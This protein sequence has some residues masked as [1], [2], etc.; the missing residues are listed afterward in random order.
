MRVALAG[1]V[2]VVLAA[3]G[4]SFGIATAQDGERS[5]FVRFVENQLSTPDRQI[6]LGEID[7]ALSSDVRLSQITIADREGVWLTVENVHL[8]WSRLA[9]LRGRLDVDLLE[10]DSIT[11]ER[12]PIAG[13][14]NEPIDDTPFTLPDL[15]VTI[16]LDRLS[17][18]EVSIAEGIIGPAA[19]LGIDGEIALDDGA[20]DTSLQIERR[21]RPGTLGL[22]ASFDSDSRDLAVDF[23]VSEPEDGVIAN[24]L[25]VE[26]RPPIEFAIQGEGPLGEF[27]AQIALRASGETL[28]Q[29]TTRIDRQE[30]GLA[31]SA[32]LAGNIAALV[33][34]L[35][36]PFVDA[37]TNLD[38]DV[39]RRDDGSV[40]VSRGVVESGVASVSFA[41]ELGADYVPT[42][43]TFQAELENPDG[44]PI[45][46][47][48]GG[49][50]STVRALK[51]DA[52]LGG[53][54]GERFVAEASL[55]DLDT[56]VVATPAATVR[57]EGD[58]TNLSDPAT[59]SVTFQATGRADRL[60]SRSDAVAD[61]L[62]SSLALDVSGAW[63]AGA[64][65][66]ITNASL[67]TDNVEAAFAGTVGD[68]LD[69]TYR[70]EA[71]NIEAFEGLAGRDLGGTAQLAAE[72]SV[73]FSGLINLG[74]DLT[75]RNLSVGI[76]PV[77]GLL[78]GATEI[79]GRVV[80]SETGIAFDAL[81]VSNPQLSVAADGAVSDTEANLEA[82]VEL[83]DLAALN[84]ET[85]GP[86]TARLTVT[87]APSAPEVDAQVTSPGLTLQDKTLADLQ[88]GFEG[89]LQ[90]ESEVAFDLDGALSV[91]ASYDGAPVALTAQI[92]T[93]EAGR[94][95]RDLSADIAGATANGTLTLTDAGRA[96]GDLSLDV[97]DLST[98]AS[99]ALTE[100]SGS[101]QADVSL[102]VRDED[103]IASVDLTARGV[104]VADAFSLEFAS[105]D[106][107][108]E[109]VFGVPVIE[110][111]A[112][113]LGVEAA[114]FD[115]RSVTLVSQREGEA[116]VLSLNADVQGA[117][118]EATGR[119]AK[120]EDGFLAALSAFEL[121]R[122]GLDARLVAPAEVRVVGET[123]TISDV[124]LEVGEGRLNLE[125]TA[126]ETLDLSASLDALPLSIA[127][128]VR[129][130]L[131]VGGTVSG[132]LTLTGT[133]EAPVADATLRAQ[134]V[135]AALLRERGIEPLSIDADASY[136]D[137][138]ATIERLATTVG[139]G[140]L[141]AEGTVGEVLDLTLDVA[142]LPLA[143][144]NAAQPELDVSGTLSGEVD[145]AGTLEAPRA[146]F[147]ASLDQATA[148]PL[149]EAGIDPVDANVA[150]SFADGTATIETLSANVGG[151]EVS[152]SGTVGE[153]LDLTASVRD[154][155]LSLA[156]AVRPDLG[157]QGALSAEVT[158]TGSLEAPDVRFEV[159]APEVTAAATRSAG[160]PAAS[161][162]ASGTANRTS[163]T[164]SEALITIG[165]G[166]AS[167]EG[168]AGLDALDLTVTLEALPLAL[169]NVASPEL[170]VRGSLSGSLDVEGT[171]ANPTVRFD[172]DVPEVSAEPTR[173][174][175]LP[176]ASA[177][178]AGVFEDGTARLDEAVVEVGGGTARA[179]GTVGR[180]LALD[181]EVTGLPLGLANA[182]RPELGLA[183]T[184]SANASA[185]GLI[186]DPNVSFDA[187]VAGFS[188]AQLESA[189]VGPLQIDAA[190]SFADGT[191]VIQSA[192]A[193]GSQIALTASGTV[194]LSG[195]GL[196]VTANARAPLSLADRFVASRG[197]R[198]GGEVVA[199]VRVA[200]SLANP[201]VTGTIEGRGVTF[202]DPQT[203]VEI[204]GGTLVVRL[205]GDSAV[206]ETFR[207]G[208]GE[209][210]ITV[211]G[212]VGIGNGFPA[213]I[214]I[215]LD[216]A[217]YADGRLVTVTLDG[218]LRITGP[219]TEGPLIAGEVLIDR[220]EITVP[221]S[222]GGGATLIEV[223]HMNLPSDVAET[224]RRAE[225]GPFAKSDEGGA[226]GE[227]GGLRLDVL[228]RAPARVFVRGRGIDAELGGEVRITGPIG[229]IS[230]I[231]QLE[232]IR[233]RLVILGQRIVFTE[234]SLAFFGD[235]NPSIRLVAETAT[236]E[237]T[238]RV[239]I[240]GPANEPDIRFESVPQLPQDEVLAQ[241]LFGRSI[242]DLSAFQ[243]AQ[244]AAAVA[245]LAGG[246][247]GPSILDQV[248]VATGLDNL[249][250]ITD[251]QGNTAAQAGRYI[252]DN[253]YVGVRAGESSGVT[254]NLDV[255]R[256]LTVRGEALTDDTSLGVY[257]ELEY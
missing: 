42:E 109:D 237:V 128:V 192:S 176:P 64:P 56:P 55:T 168:T 152:A 219:L 92:E 160:L 54:V 66:R 146:E 47:P 36:D 35:Y 104:S 46:L 88:V 131:G 204:A 161:L 124:A 170:D 235:L 63:E 127:N 164:L 29:G 2:L 148:A 126:G 223:A 39:L 162:T 1:F 180:D 14:N 48:G 9:L 191:V 136:A 250:I 245:E 112:E 26:G 172:I 156:D 153:T 236:K 184:L 178:V 208:L 15:P 134:G 229:A 174:S 243:L 165:A 13:E 87:G 207:A 62:G 34:D 196:D 113:V 221:A 206:I 101:V 181:F 248:R 65:A 256:N 125:G 240:D 32:D 177:R 83:T 117:R 209:G 76:A 78:E 247:G 38:I 190:G 75:A 193:N 115:V 52:K 183:G 242:S 171:P 95:L 194:P 217:R 79:T 7:G 198:V 22:D 91:N 215:V 255:T 18:P 135:T 257:Y 105:A 179:T 246:G 138:T 33:A 57:A 211:S 230:P 96:A 31:F 97:P 252:A 244:L 60:A 123:I 189:G 234:G 121:A 212:S 19:E 186:Q 51:I 158:A 231:G 81:R 226:G 27:V 114:G 150:G 188:A 201:D 218:D 200:G 197:A 106:L 68:G 163:V 111:R 199:D 144:A 21:D 182:A 220:A 249:E 159:R 8:V 110:G 157:V 202:N 155:P 214:S 133:R 254:I 93:A 82:T 129:D 154:L 145:L 30:E 98:L 151:G 37:G 58:A 73:G 70:L 203:G 108:V 142:D 185:T 149:R 173:R 107:A 72:G 49:G 139:G 69:G 100:A 41:A 61:A 28:L 103:Q 253:V 241:L 94:T 10:A 43:L 74:L 227:G 119:L 228:V 169:A 239:I 137:G 6:R 45:A 216:D 120:L 3:V 140:S 233:G 213:D 222:L 16:L 25:N 84:P 86:I 40:S 116:S 238:V 147:R 175:G 90:R 12:P 24:A 251:P 23:T 77:D 59:R 118:L 130:D 11:I 17:V 195:G 143:L 167:A 205:T 85:A 67:V 210:S 80:R 132:D 4:V 20:L 44:T 122:D 5:R 225:V 166:S 71:D 187:A 53:E 99:L 50:E 102:A 224:L 232:L 141:S 89:V